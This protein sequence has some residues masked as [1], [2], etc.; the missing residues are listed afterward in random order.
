M[1]SL[2]TNNVRTMT[3]PPLTFNRPED[4]V[5]SCQWQYVY[6]VHS[7]KTCSKCWILMDV[8]DFK[9]VLD[10]LRYLPIFFFFCDL[11]Y[12]YCVLRHSCVHYSSFMMLLIVTR[13]WLKLATL[14]A[15][16]MDQCIYYNEFWPFPPLVC[17]VML[18][19]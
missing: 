2:W 14:V 6:H 10:H 18:C 13:V 4:K 16:A 3:T 7:M 12:K 1:H 11:I 5:L 8:R 15:L 9:R 19:Y 17:C